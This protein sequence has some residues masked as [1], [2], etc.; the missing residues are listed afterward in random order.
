MS[1]SRTALLLFLLACTVYLLPGRDG[2]TGDTIPAQ[3]LPLSVLGEGDLDFNEFVCPPDAATGRATDYA[4]GRCLTPLPYYF[5]LVQGRVVSNYP[6]IAGLLNIPAHAVAGALGVD[7]VVERTRLALVTAAWTSALAVAFLYLF[8]SMLPLARATQVGTTLVFAFGTLVWGVAGHGLWQH[9][10]SLMCLTAALW[11]LARGDRRS[12]AWAGLALGL[13]VFTRPTNILLALP[14][15]WYV[16]RTHRESRAAFLVPFAV[17]LLLMVWYS[18][19]WL[20]S[21]TALGQGQR[22]RIGSNPLEGL[23][24]ILV[25][26]ARGLFVFSPV[27]LLA[28]L[29]VPRTWAKEQ[30]IPLLRPLLLGTAGIIGVHALWAIW[31]GGHSFGYRMLS[32]TLPGFMLLLALAWESQLRG[33]PV[34]VAT[35]AGLLLLSVWANAMGALVAPCGFDMTPVPVDLHPERLWDVADTELVRCTE[36]VLQG[37]VGR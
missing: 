3:L 28:L 27:L 4:P 19:A 15:A 36:R 2:G 10:P 30:R 29:A 9:G 20:G 13:A 12:L 1:R 11:C 14:L 17:P 24:G 26:P 32:E 33:R 18:W 8:L 16:W 35:A 21:L 25:S 37:P 22:M 23:A 5:V 7:T 6:I 31:W 34:R